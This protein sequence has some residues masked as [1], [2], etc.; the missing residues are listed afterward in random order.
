MEPLPKKFKLSRKKYLVSILHTLNV[1]G[2]V[3]L[4]CLFF[5]IILSVPFLLSEDQTTKQ[6]NQLIC[7]MS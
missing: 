4:L 2:I 1:H 7:L 3:H 5:Q 6:E